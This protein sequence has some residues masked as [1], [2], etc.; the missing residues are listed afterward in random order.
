[1]EEIVATISDLM[2]TP[3]ADNP[4]SVADRR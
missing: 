3:L 1:V 4:D 2:S